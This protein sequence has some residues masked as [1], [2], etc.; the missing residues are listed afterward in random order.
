MATLPNPLPRL[1]ADPSGGALGLP[2]PEGRLIDTTVDGTWHEPLLWHAEKR[3]RP[4]D[5]SALA[6]AAPRLGLLP[7]LVETGGPQGA[8]G[9]LW[10]LDPERT[11]Y[12]GDHDAE[13]VLMDLG[14]YGGENA[15]GEEP[16]EREWPGLAEALPFGADP[17]EAAAALAGE[18]TDETRA[19]RLK[20]PCLALV[21]ARR[22]AD[23]PAAIGWTGPMNT[24]NDVARLCAVLRSWEDRFGARVVALGFD[25]L[26]VSVAAPAGTLEQAEAIAAEHEAFCPDIWQGGHRTLRE[27]AQAAVLGRSRWSFWWD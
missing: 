26:V 10:E 13:D 15:D 18:L 21:S 9:D 3:A 2:L 1:A 12:P 22:S 8:P 5:W 4:G 27:Y 17:D 20:E 19:A 11:S 6:A 24:E 23:I 14:G 7:V 16:E 25:R